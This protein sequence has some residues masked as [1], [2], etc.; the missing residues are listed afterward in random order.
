MEVD[1]T[2]EQFLAHSDL[3]PGSSDQRMVIS[4]SDDQPGVSSG[5]ND[6]FTV[7]SESHDQPGV[8]SGS[9]DQFTVMPWSSDQ[10]TIISNDQEEVSPSDQPRVS[11]GRLSR[12]GKLLEMK[13]IGAQMSDLN[14]FLSAIGNMFPNQHSQE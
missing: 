11:G 1:I 6:Q 3:T 8:S 14:L 7:M 5:S 13:R 10:L 4:G 9:D 2:K 12:S